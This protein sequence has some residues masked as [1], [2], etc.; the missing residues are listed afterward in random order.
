MT[1]GDLYS[2]GH[3]GNQPHTSQWGQRGHR[4]GPT[5]Q[6]DGAGDSDDVNV[7]LF[8]KW[9]PWCIYIYILYIYTYSVYSI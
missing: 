6:V 5:R 3:N 2:M 9:A 8:S 7:S 4:V 1:H